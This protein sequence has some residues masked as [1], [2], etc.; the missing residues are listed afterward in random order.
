MR[1][2]LKDM[3][4]WMAQRLIVRATARAIEM[5]EDGEKEQAPKALPAPRLPQIE[6]N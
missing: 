3:I 4:E 1:N 6:L 5:L 2:Y